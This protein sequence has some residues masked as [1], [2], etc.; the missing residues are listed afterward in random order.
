MTAA[1]IT[2]AAY[3]ATANP[4]IPED[5][6]QPLWV[7]GGLVGIAI[8]ANQVMGAIITFRKLKGSDPT[9]DI[10]YA[11]KIEVDDVKKDVSVLRG[12]V[13]GISHTLQ[14]ELRAIHRAL[15]RIE[16]AMGTD[17]DFKKRG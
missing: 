1:A 7:L 2:L 8:M 4:Q 16:G 12:E 15:G 9:A 6:T 14:N 11:S 17:P 5:Q 3:L 13:K 10:R